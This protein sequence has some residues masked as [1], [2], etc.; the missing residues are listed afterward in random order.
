M[1]KKALNALKKSIAHWK[2]M[3]DDKAPFDEEPVSEDCALCKLYLH[4]EEACD[5]CPVYEKTK[6][7]HCAGTPYPAAWR[8]YAD[9]GIASIQFRKAARRQIEFLESLLP[10]KSSKK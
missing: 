8:A 7:S 3:A 5:G 1:T 6:R 10:S 2:R 9:R 4:E